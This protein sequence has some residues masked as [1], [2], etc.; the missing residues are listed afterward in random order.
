MPSKAAADDEDAAREIQVAGQDRAE[1]VDGHGVDSGQD[2]CQTPE[3]GL[4]LQQHVGQQ[5]A[6]D[7]L[8]DSCRAADLLNGSTGA[9]TTAP[10]RLMISTAYR[11]SKNAKYRSILPILH[12]IVDWA[13]F[14]GPAKYRSTSREVSFHG[15]V[16]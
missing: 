7:R 2:E 12:R 15:T 11:C 16:P 8:G 6:G 3:G 14:P 9:S 1:I 10:K 5:L 13:R 4:P